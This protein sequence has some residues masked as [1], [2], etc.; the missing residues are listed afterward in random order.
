MSGRPVSG[1]VRKVFIIIPPLDYTVTVVTE[2]L[3]IP[4]EILPLPDGRLLVT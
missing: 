4:W 1:K 2:E 3:E